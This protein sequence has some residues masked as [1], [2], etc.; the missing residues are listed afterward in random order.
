MKTINTL[1]VI[2]TLSLALLIILIL[3]SAPVHAAK[4]PKVQ[5]EKVETVSVD[6]N[7]QAMQSIKESLLSMQL[8]PVKTNANLAL[9]LTTAAQLAKAK[10]ALSVAKVSRIAD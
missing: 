9:S 6:L 8:A 5:L 7:L 3:V 4:L 2:I 1:S 10:P